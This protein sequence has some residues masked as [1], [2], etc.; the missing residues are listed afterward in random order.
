MQ[1][2]GIEDKELT[3]LAVQLLAADLTRGERRYFSG[4]GGLEIDRTRLAND[5]YDCYQAAKQAWARS[6]VG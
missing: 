2:P 3:V 5:L 1:I 6:S 4:L